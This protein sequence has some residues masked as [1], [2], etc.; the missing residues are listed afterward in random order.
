MT[1]YIE[2]VVL[3]FQN[4]DKESIV[5][6]NDVVKIVSKN[7]DH[8][9]TAEA[10]HRRSITFNGKSDKFKIMNELFFNKSDLCKIEVIYDDQSVEVIETDDPS[11]EISDESDQTFEM[12]IFSKE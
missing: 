3:T 1:K 11:I 4:G 7:L 2:R 8:G 5:E 10:S 9:L 12:H 6:L